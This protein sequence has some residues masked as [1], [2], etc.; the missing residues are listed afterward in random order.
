MRE[1]C[2]LTELFKDECAHC[3]GDFTPD[4]EEI[5]IIKDIDK[6]LDENK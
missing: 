2:D 6:W 3:Q 4:E 5:Q 1:R